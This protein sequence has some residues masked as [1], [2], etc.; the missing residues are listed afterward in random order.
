[1]TVLLIVVIALVGL[2]V[3]MIKMPGE[4]FRGALPPLDEG[5]RELA[6]KLERHVETL[7]INPAGRHYLEKKGLAAA[8]DYI[9]AQFEASGY[10][11]GF[12]SYEFGG[13]DYAN[14]EVTRA[15]N[16]LV[17]EVIVVGAHYDAVVGAPGANDNGSGVAALLELARRFVDIEL[18]RTLRFVA[19]VNEEPPHFLT[20]TMGSDAYARRA[21]RQRENIVAMFALETIGYYRDD[22][23]SQHY[24]PPLN[25]FYPQQGNFIAFVGN[26]RSRALVTRS[27][28]A[29]RQHARFPSEGIAAPAFIPGVDWSDHRSFWK[30]GYPA[31][32][33]TDTAPYRY[34][35]YHSAQDTPDKVDYQRM[36]YVVDGLAKMIEALARGE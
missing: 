14:I 4:S 11:V 6:L 5:G 33:I 15:G 8:R 12:Q 34:P 21:A 24:P 35:W 25:L 3:Y 31:L 13:D 26:L 22:P 16:R 7:C 20:G 17:D 1:M 27:L 9:A 32:M 36:V 19:F 28:R 2:L 10:A 30:Q 29:F 18:P 23:G